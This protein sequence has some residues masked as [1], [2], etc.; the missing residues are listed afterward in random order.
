MSELVR[1]TIADKEVL[2]PAYPAHGLWV[3][4][5][6]MFRR[7]IGATNEVIM[8]TG[9]RF[10]FIDVLEVDQVKQKP[11]S[12]CEFF[13][14]A[15]PEEMQR[16]SRYVIEY[17]VTHIF[18]ANLPHQHLITAAFLGGMCPSARIII[19]KPLDVNFELIQSLT[20][21]KTWP[22]LID[23]IFL[24]DH[25]RNKGA[26][27][28]VYQHLPALIERY[29]KVLSFQF[30]L[31]ESRTVED[32]KRGEALEAGVI[33][34]LASHLFSL[35]QL[36]FLGDDGP[37]PALRDKKR[38]VRNASL[39][40]TKVAK[41][42]YSGCEIYRERHEEVETFAAIEVEVIG[43]YSRPGSRLLYPLRIPGI[44]VVAKAVKASPNTNFNLKGF[45]LNQELQPR[46]VNLVRNVINP[47]VGGPDLKIDVKEDG[48]RSPIVNSLRDEVLLMQPGEQ[49][50][51]AFVPYARAAQNTIY[52]RQALEMPS[53]L[54]YHEPG[55]DLD[56]VMAKCAAAGALD[57]RWLSSSGYADIGFD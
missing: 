43:E 35:V 24:Y 42:R 31:V 36:F 54:V 46:S 51:P 55:N 37:G 20:D 6:D 7:A 19:T 47:S 30:Y 32:E 38:R 56:A 25:Y 28:P 12:D 18:I 22:G 8:Q 44:L 57:P 13:N 1:V 2:L 9:M 21:G 4:C 52:I 26:V 10:S 39:R 23:R 14:I 41:A 17:P 3:G 11:P 15:R 49:Q 5:G 53:G 16:L 50:I 27:E 29:G 48:F 40:I 34:D 45:R 33:F